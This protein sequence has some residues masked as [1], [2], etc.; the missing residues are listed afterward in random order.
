MAYS[1][2]YAQKSI[3]TQ[4]FK[5]VWR[6]YYDLITMTIT[7]LTI[8]CLLSSY[9]DLEQFLSVNTWNTNKLLFAFFKN[10]QVKCKM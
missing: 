3:E 5:R 7:K 1:L 4:V 10:L 8:S 9:Y 2:I 6:D